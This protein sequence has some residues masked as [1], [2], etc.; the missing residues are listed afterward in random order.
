MTPCLVHVNERLALLG[1]SH[2]SPPEPVI[3]CLKR[4][5]PKHVGLEL[6]S[7]R[8]AR[9]FPFGIDEYLKLPQGQR[10]RMQSRL[11]HGRDQFEAAMW[12]HGRAELHLMDRVSS[13]TLS[14]LG[15]SLSEN[16]LKDEWL[17]VLTWPYAVL[18]LR[19]HILYGKPR[20][21]PRVWDIDFPL[22]DGTPEQRWA[23]FLDTHWECPE[24]QEVKSKV[25]AI[26]IDE[27]DRIF[28]HRLREIN[29]SNDLCV[30]VV[31]KLHLPG[32][33]RHLNIR[34]EASDSTCTSTTTSSYHNYIESDDSSTYPAEL[35]EVPSNR[36]LRRRILEYALLRRIKAVL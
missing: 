14:R 15:A 27:R 20:R 12:A 2:V 9:L 29:E 30:A 25:D 8:Y 24:I 5:S 28:A 34:A 18:R 23:K 7:E 19:Q 26:V 31:G 36:S 1:V 33:L 13:T 10:E 6:C 17:R 4:L 3:E 32:I 22:H 21:L 16:I 11:T 35:F